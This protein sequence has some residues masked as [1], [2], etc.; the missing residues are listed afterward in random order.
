MGSRSTVSPLGLLIE[1]LRAESA[2]PPM[3][4]RARSRVVVPLAR[5]AQGAP[6]PDLV[7]ESGVVSGGR[8]PSSRSWRWVPALALH[9]VFAAAV[10]VIPLLIADELPLPATGAKVFFVQSIVPPPPPPASA[11]APRPAATTPAIRRSVASSPSSPVAP[12]ARAEVKPEDLEPPAS[13][14]PPAM[15]ALSAEGV[16]GGVDEGVPGAIVGGVIER[17]SA[18][19]PVSP[20][21]RVGGADRKSVV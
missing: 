5:R 12:A 6:E 16:P 13:V 10:I 11:A 1:D 18:T 21:L 4:R 2:L 14:D 9:A 15:P 19:E 7:L 20:A 8:A 3:P 17:V